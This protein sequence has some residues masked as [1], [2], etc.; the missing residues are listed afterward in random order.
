MKLRWVGL[1]LWLAFGAVGEVLRVEEASCPV[2]SETRWAF[3]DASGA[4][5][6]MECWSVCSSRFNGSSLAAATVASPSTGSCLCFPTCEC[7]GPNSALAPKYSTIVSQQQGEA[8]PT[9]CDETLAYDGT[10]FESQRYFLTQHAHYDVAVGARCAPPPMEG[11][12][13]SSAGPWLDDEDTA[14]A[15]CLFH[16]LELRVDA[17]A[18]LDMMARTCC[19]V[20]RCDCIDPSFAGIVA[21]NY[22]QVSKVPTD[23]CAAADLHPYETH[24]VDALCGDTRRGRE[25]TPL[26]VVRLSSSSSSS[27]GS[28][29][30]NETILLPKT[31]PETTTQA[32]QEQLERCWAV[33][34]EALQEDLVGVVATAEDAEEVLCRCY[35]TCDCA[36]RSGADHYL[37]LAKGNVA[38]RCLW[39][40]DDEVVD[41]DQLHGDLLDAAHVR[42]IYATQYH[43]ISQVGD[44]G[45]TRDDD[46]DDDETFCVVAPDIADDDEKR[47]NCFAHCAEATG[48]LPGA[49]FGDDDKCC[50]TSS[51]DCLA[52]SDAASD[53]KGSYVTIHVGDPYPDAHCPGPAHARPPPP[54]EEEEEEE[55]PLGEEEEENVD[56][57]K[58][59]KTKKKKKTTS[60]LLSPS[61]P[62]SSGVFD[63]AEYVIILALV[64]V[65]LATLAVFTEIA[66]MHYERSPS[67]PPPRDAPLVNLNALHKFQRGPATMV[68]GPHARRAG[69]PPPTYDLT[70]PLTAEMRP[71]DAVAER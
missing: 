26:A 32:P 22:H 46:D 39:D 33:C 3:V 15:A 16:C 10:V 28:A 29:S 31:N 4:D 43:T 36:A 71:F 50:C 9:A 44:C 64:F 67:P 13:C 25:A 56:E 8:P 61:S 54:E 49:T 2:T 68:L 47:L 23:A 59:K 20:P 41:A 30:T 7:L 69:E 19:C 27:S 5:V 42:E 11:L 53:A 34:A 55:T 58:T 6:A 1:V 70:A 65:G 38:D 57:E 35:D 37:A 40:Q 17:A 51:C 12:T 24:F 48:A 18:S 14:L 62:F 66:Y 52:S 45:S 21:L 60:A 63:G